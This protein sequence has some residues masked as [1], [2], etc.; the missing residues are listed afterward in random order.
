MLLPSSKSPFLPSGSVAQRGGEG[1][2][3]LPGPVNT[4]TQFSSSPSHT[5]LCQH[6][7]MQTFVSTIFKPLIFQRCFKT[8]WM[9]NTS[10]SC[11]W[12]YFSRSIF[13]LHDPGRDR[14]GG[15]EGGDWPGPLSWAEQK[16]KI[17]S[18]CESG[19]VTEMDPDNKSRDNI[20]PGLLNLVKTQV[21]FLLLRQSINETQL[22]SELEIKVK[23][24]EKTHQAKGP[25]LQR[26]RSKLS[27]FCFCK[28]SGQ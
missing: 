1:V 3:W 24:K 21:N 8:V 22:K 27:F 28:R 17:S 10:C 12:L 5:E 13:L 7:N 23:L 20:W 18:C 19:T 25:D 9:F 2:T 14:G 16:V 6:T 26:P 4:C 15:S 11:S